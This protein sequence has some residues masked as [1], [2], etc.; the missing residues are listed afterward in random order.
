MATHHHRAGVASATTTF[1]ARTEARTSTQKTTWF[2]SSR[3]RWTRE[4]P[5]MRTSPHET[6]GAPF[7]RRLPAERRAARSTEG[8]DRT[9]ELADPHRLPLTA[10]RP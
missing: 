9:K 10:N 5:T 3:W 7:P 6:E 4:M 2:Q 1:A 8:I